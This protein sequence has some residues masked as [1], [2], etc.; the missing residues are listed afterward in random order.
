MGLDGYIDVEAEV[1]IP[2]NIDDPDGPTKTIIDSF[3]IMGSQFGLEETSI[4]KAFH[5]DPE[6]AIEYF[7]DVEDGTL[8]QH[9]V[10]NDGSGFT[11][12]DNQIEIP[13]HI[14][15]PGSDDDNGEFDDVDEATF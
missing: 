3:R 4:W 9:C 14:I 5:N 8:R 15:R 12:V 2:V 13:W 10:M 6:F 1:E 7:V 11:V